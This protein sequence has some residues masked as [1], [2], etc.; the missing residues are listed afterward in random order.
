MC[1][2]WWFIRRIHSTDSVSIIL[3]FTQAYTCTYMVHM[4]LADQGGAASIS[5]RGFRFLRFG[6]QV[7]LNVTALGAGGPGGYGKSWIRHC[8]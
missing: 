7:L 3:P 8:M 4:S 6:V 5:L 1:A 2:K